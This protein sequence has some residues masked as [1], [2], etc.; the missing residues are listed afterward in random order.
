MATYYIT[1]AGSGAHNGSSYANADSVAHHNAATYAADDVIYLCDTITS[2]VSPPSSG[3]SDAHRSTYRGDYAG[4]AGVLDGV[5]VSGNGGGL[6]INGKNYITISKLTV[7]ATSGSGDNCNVWIFNSDGI[8]LSG[9]TITYAEE[10]YG[11]WI[12][13]SCSDWIIEDCDVSHNDWCG[14]LSGYEGEYHN[15]AGIICRNT[16][17]ANGQ[18]T[19]STYCTPGNSGSCFYHAIYIDVDTDGVTEIYQNKL[20][21]T[22]CGHGVKAKAG[23][24][25]HHN[26]FKNNSNY[27]LYHVAASGVVST[28]IAHHNVLMNPNGYGVGAEHNIFFYEESEATTT[29]YTYNNTIYDDGSGVGIQSAWAEA[30][31]GK[32]PTNWYIWN[33]IIVSG[34]G[35]AMVFPTDGIPSGTLSINYNLAYTS[36]ESEYYYGA[37]ARSFAQWKGLGFDANG[38]CDENPLLN[39]PA[40]DECW[41]QVDSPAIDAGYDLG[42][43]YDECLLQAS[44]WPSSVVIGDSDS[45]GAGWD[46]GAYEYAGGDPLGSPFSKDNVMILN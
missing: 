6:H 42:D 8:T 40:S 44:S 14:V 39:D 2:Q 23:V 10:S 28:Q 18:S 15:G 35:R 32:G 7:T 26:F 45:Y 19:N 24:N 22:R 25:I 1:Q 37:S 43:D 29:V 9:C 34:S 41:T 27:N 46:I 36:A 20:I 21:N 12:W 13:Y 30:G 3:S 4:H 31:S 33:N 38:K 5:S 17:D 16:F 11:I